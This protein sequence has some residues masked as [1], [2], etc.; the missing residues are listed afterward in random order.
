MD[1]KIH[2][3][4]CACRDCELGV[5]KQHVIGCQCA[6]CAYQRGA[7]PSLLDDVRRNLGRIG[8]RID[9]AADAFDAAKD[10]AAKAAGILTPEERAFAERWFRGLLRR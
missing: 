3:G 5:T 1:T 10:A 8:K 7:R 2:V 4:G 6:D 9:K